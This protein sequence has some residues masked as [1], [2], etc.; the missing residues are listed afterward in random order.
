MLSETKD[1]SSAVPASGTARCSGKRA[2]GKCSHV[3]SVHLQHVREYVIAVLRGEGS[4]STGVQATLSR[5][6]PAS[7]YVALLP[8][9]WALIKSE[10]S[11]HLENEQSVWVAVLE[12]ALR[13]SSS[14]AA[15]R[16]T[17]EFL[18]RLLLVCVHFLASFVIFLRRVAGQHDSSIR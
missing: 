14:S 7:A 12:H 1:A 17:I 15:K 2:A 6:L 4:V 8:T 18:G 11:Q 16:H 3:A 10:E 5:S 13:I 9:I